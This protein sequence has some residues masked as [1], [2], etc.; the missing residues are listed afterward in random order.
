MKGLKSFLKKCAGM[1]PMFCT[2][3][4]FVMVASKLTDK[5]IVMTKGTGG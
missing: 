1:T 4:A 3:T 5:F 2:L